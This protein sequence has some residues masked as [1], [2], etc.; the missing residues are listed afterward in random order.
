M[1]CSVL[2]CSVLFC[3][4]LFCSVLFCRGD[5]S[6]KGRRVWAGGIEPTDTT[7]SNPKTATTDGAGALI[8]TLF[9]FLLLSRINRDAKNNS[10]FDTAFYDHFDRMISKYEEIILYE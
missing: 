1:F 10:S 9:L 7:F 4:V 2:F 6:A 5:S 3:S 8:E